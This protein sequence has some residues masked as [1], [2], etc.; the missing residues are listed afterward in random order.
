MIDLVPVP[1]AVAQAVL[2]C[3]DLALD[4][5]LDRD[6]GSPRVADWPH[7]DTPDAL[8]PLAEHPEH[9]GKGS[10][11]IRADGVVI[12]DCGWFGPPSNGEVEIGYGLAPSARGRGSGSEAVR[13][14]VDWVTEQGA[15]VVRAE[16]LPGNEASVRLLLRLGFAVVG[17]RA[18][19][20]VLSR[21]VE[22][23][24]DLLR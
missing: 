19:H 10:F 14:L 23:S 13:R 15:L 21:S 8:R 9:G 1:L 12:G 18:G 2:A 17:E 16:V 5:A 11:L 24:S 20:V 6:L 3:D 7:L 4:A 22:R